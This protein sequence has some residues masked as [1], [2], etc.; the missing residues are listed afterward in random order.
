MANAPEAYSTKSWGT[1][2]ECGFTVLISRKGAKGKG[3]PRTAL[4]QEESN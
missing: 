3:G 1:L 2:K 4:R